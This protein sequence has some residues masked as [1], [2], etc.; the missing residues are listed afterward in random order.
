MEEPDV[1][2]GVDDGAVESSAWHG[3]MIGRLRNLSRQ[4][5]MRLDVTL[6]PTVQP[7]LM[8]HRIEG[9]PVLPGVMGI[10]AFAEA[11]RILAPE[12]DVVAIEDVTFESA[13]KF[14]RQQ[15]RTLTVDTT[16][17]PALDGVLASSRLIGTR[18]LPNRPEP[19]EQVHF[20][21][22]V[23]LGRAPMCAPIVPPRSAP[24]RAVLA[25]DIYQVFFH[26]PAY[27]VLD[28][29]WREN[30]FTIGLLAAPLPANHSPASERLIMAPRLI[31]LC[32]QTAA[33]MELVEHGYMGLPRSVSRVRTI[34]A[35]EEANGPLY[36]LV[37][38]GAE[39]ESYDAHV[40]D[41]SG[42]VFVELHGYR[43]VRWPVRVE[44]RLLLPFCEGLGLAPVLA[45]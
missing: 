9:I 36:A 22:R 16:F 41:A 19:E 27:Q 44:E 20:T 7:F 35:S 8:D 42:T 1:T 26:G 15:P 6:D 43:T 24:Q 4:S 31:E 29:A 33:I 30:G 17:Q 18:T 40:V 34:R 23:R 12:L 11:A 25:S 39:P 3:P 32:F 5:G 2:G 14:F 13:V 37:R 28:R 45:P 21:G 38:P 10:E